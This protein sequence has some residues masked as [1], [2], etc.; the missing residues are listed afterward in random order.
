MIE[1][2][3]TFVNI[4]DENVFIHFNVDEPR[5]VLYRS[6]ELFCRI[7]INNKSQTSQRCLFQKLIILWEYIITLRFIKL[8]NFDRL[9]NYL[10]ILFNVSH[11]YQMTFIILNARY[12]PFLFIFTK[13]NKLIASH[14][15]PSSRISLLN[16]NNLKHINIW[17]V[18]YSFKS[19]IE[20]NWA[21]N[22]EFIFF[23]NEKLRD[24]CLVIRLLMLI[25]P[26]RINVVSSEDVESNGF[27]R[28][29]YFIILKSFLVWKN[30][31]LKINHFFPINFLFL[32][33]IL[34][35]NWG[36]LPLVALK[37]RW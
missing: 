23:F 9:K 17:G 11:R 22:Q 10:I 34:N 35:I 25:H 37:H 27:D 1:N 3:K 32:L 24:R 6:W 28:C 18:V 13:E 19:F 8:Y 4:S 21:H 29:Y 7:L 30:L 26:L 16:L 36:L 33:L 20:F 12:K 31:I 15:F 2:L 5:H 14:C